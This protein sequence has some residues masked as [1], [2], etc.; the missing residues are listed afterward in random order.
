[1]KQKTITLDL[2]QEAWESLG[3]LVLNAYL[4]DPTDGIYIELLQEYLDSGGK[5][6]DL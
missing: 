1:M 3:N 4:T 6:E 5:I 2:T